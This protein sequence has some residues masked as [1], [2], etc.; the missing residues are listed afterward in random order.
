VS[1]LNGSGSITPQ[2]LKRLERLL[3]WIAIP[4]LAVIL[5]SLQVMGF[6]S[7]S[8]SPAWIGI[9]ALIPEAVLAGEVW[10]VVTFLALPLT[11]SP[12]WLFFTLCFLYFV[13]NTL[14]QEWGAFRTTFYV[15][16]STV[17]TVLYSLIF[18]Y[19][20]LDVRHF[21][22]SLFLA[23][24]ALFP[25]YQVTLFFAIPVKLKILAMITGG[26]I[27]LELFRGEWSDR[28]Y[29][30]AIYSNFLLFFGPAAISA[31]LQAKR[32]RDY[33]KRMRE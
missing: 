24:A 14:E 13:V 30:L 11:Y 22:A 9:L 27:L 23:A 17:V 32:R 10:R 4:H 16:V 33:H 12:L 29:L 7:V 28:L 18:S 26:F 5:I 8:T 6:F 15:L 21:E 1:M 19:S 3:G 25:N 2:W 31:L 20:V